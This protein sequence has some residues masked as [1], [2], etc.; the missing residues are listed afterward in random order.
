LNQS[1][2]VPIFKQQKNQIAKFL[3]KAK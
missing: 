1:G 3:L 2:T